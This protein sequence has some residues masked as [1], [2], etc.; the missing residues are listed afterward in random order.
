MNFL[1][2]DE[3]NYTEKFFGTIY[4]HAIEFSSFVNV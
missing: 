4:K 2:K 1:H 3:F